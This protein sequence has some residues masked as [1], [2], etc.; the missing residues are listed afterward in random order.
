MTIKLLWLPGPGYYDLRVFAG[1]D[2]DK[3]AFV[4]QLRLPPAEAEA[5]RSRLL[6]GD[7]ALG[8]LVV[9]EAGWTE[10]RTPS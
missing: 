5:F 8:E 2:P 6:A 9:S 3:R 4:G 1:P 10:L 7:A